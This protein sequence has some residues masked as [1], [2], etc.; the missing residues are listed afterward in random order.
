MPSIR[1]RRDFPAEIQ[2]VEGKRVS[3]CHV[4]VEIETTVTNGQR[5]ITW[6]GKVTSLTDPDVTLAGPYL[7]QPQGAPAS[8]RINVYAGAADRLGITSDEYEFHGDD[9]PPEVP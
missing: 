8:A 2:S 6:A 7:L 5:E 3:E 1:K 4:Y 9:A